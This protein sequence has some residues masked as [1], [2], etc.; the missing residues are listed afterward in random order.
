MI[1]N[2]NGGGGDRGP[3]WESEDTTVDIKSS[4]RMHQIW[5]VQ[6]PRGPIP[7]LMTRT[8]LSCSSLLF[9]GRATKP[10]YKKEEKNREFLL[11]LFL[12]INVVKFGAF[13]FLPPSSSSCSSMESQN[14]DREMK[15]VD[16]ALV[17]FSPVSSPRIFWKSRKRSGSIGFSFSL[18]LCFFQC[19]CL[20]LDTP[21][22]APAPYWWLIYY[23]EFNSVTSYWLVFGWVSYRFLK[24]EFYPHPSLL[25]FSYSVL[26]LISDC[27]TYPEKKKSNSFEVCTLWRKI[28]LPHWLVVGANPLI[29]WN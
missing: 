3:K 29:I 12:E 9:L 15:K 18:S 2:A 27:F 14:Q 17:G 26:L 8:I 21:P 7:V 4:N 25:R 28:M 10:K 16:G 22:A 20:I 1:K 23:M 6:N 24:A 19:F 13:V 11:W 5:T